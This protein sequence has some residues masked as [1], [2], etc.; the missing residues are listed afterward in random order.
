MENF[1]DSIDEPYC[2]IRLKS[3]VHLE[4]GPKVLLA[5]PRLETDSAISGLVLCEPSLAADWLN[6]EEDEAWAHLQ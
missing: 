2:R 5:V 4:K 6:T 1:C 3:S